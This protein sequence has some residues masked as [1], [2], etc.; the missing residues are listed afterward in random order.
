[1]SKSSSTPVDPER[2][3]GANAFD[4]P[5]GYSGQGYTA[6]REIA[7]GAR[8]ADPAFRE[9]V[10]GRDLPPDAGHRAHVDP[11]TGEVHG[12]GAGTGG[13][14]AG[15]DFDQSGASGDS[16]PLTGGEGSDHQAD[17]LGPPRLG[18]RAA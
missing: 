9:Q 1:M 2:L 10:D 3:R 15:E 11:A 16:Y 6:G 7:E 8:G 13:G 14:N 18:P 17:D 4:Q 5:T 12:S